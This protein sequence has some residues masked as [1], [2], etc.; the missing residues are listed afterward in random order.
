VNPII[1]S[2]ND[3]LIAVKGN[4]PKLLESLKT[5][6]AQQEPQSVDHSIEH[7]HGRTVER[8]VSVLDTVEAIA[9]Q[10]VGVQRIICVERWG[11][12][13]HN[14]FHETMFYISSLALN[15]AGFAERIGQHW[16]LE[17]RLHWVKDVVLREDHT[18]VCDGHA[19]VNFAIV[20]TIV[21][22]LFRSHGV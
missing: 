21:V 10:W 6:F 2:G 7:S 22:N 15:A 20:R 12:R 3:Y 16:H 9:P 11:S 14:P 13:G 17:N 18:P 4:Q 5:Q 1:T 8:R 19:L